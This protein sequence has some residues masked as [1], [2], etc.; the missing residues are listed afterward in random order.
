MRKKQPWPISRRYPVIRLANEP[1]K[2]RIFENTA[3]F[4]TH[5]CSVNATSILLPLHP[6]YRLLQVKKKEVKC[7]Y[8]VRPWPSVSGYTVLGALA[9]TRFIFASRF[10]RIKM[11]FSVGKFGENRNTGPGTNKIKK[12]LAQERVKKTTNSGWCIIQRKSTWY[13]RKQC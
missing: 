10:I 2:K 3:E 5:T 6:H 7:G 12:K 1:S 8:Y 13:I 4:Q 11:L 9:R